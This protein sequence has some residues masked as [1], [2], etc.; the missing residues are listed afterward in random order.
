MPKSPR[1][2]SLLPHLILLSGTLVRAKTM[3]S[4]HPYP[5]CLI[6]QGLAHGRYPL[7][8]DGGYGQQ[9]RPQTVYYW[10]LHQRGSGNSSVGG[11]NMTSLGMTQNSHVQVTMTMHTAMSLPDL[12]T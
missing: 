3:H 5:Q 6:R 9:Q 4:L 12:T 11:L 8:Q 7:G 1:D 10:L 2:C